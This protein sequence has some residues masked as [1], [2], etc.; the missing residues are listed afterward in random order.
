L[1]VQ[2]KAAKKMGTLL[3]KIFEEPSSGVVVLTALLWVSFWAVYRVGRWTETVSSRSKNTDT[4]DE[5]L[6]SHYQNMAHIMATLDLIYVNTL[7][8][9]L[10][11][12]AHSPLSLASASL[13]AG[14]APY[15]SV[16]ALDSETVALTERCVRC[17]FFQKGQKNAD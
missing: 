11:P 12:L 1:I 4:A 6:K 13:A 16:R 9:P 3:A 17:Q 2:I 15:L 5:Q 10:V 8:T 14:E 7:K